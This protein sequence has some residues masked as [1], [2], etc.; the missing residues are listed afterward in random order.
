MYSNC[1]T[2]ESLLLVDLFWSVPDFLNPTLMFLFN[3]LT[4]YARTA[5]PPMVSPG[6]MI[7]ALDAIRG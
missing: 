2:R 5:L 4:L 6:G 7:Q 1:H 3:G